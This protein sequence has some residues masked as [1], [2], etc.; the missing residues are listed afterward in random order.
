MHKGCTK[1]GYRD[2]H[3]QN[4]MRMMHPHWLQNMKYN[5]SM[6][7]FLQRDQPITLI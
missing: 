7:N 3:A 6:S 1:M 2:Y 5:R 4:H